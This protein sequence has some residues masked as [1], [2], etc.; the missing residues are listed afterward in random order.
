[1]KP[2]ETKSVE[3]TSAGNP[4]TVPLDDRDIYRARRSKYYP[5]WTT[6]LE[7]SNCKTKE[8]GWKLLSYTHKTMDDMRA[9]KSGKNSAAALRAIKVALIDWTPSG[10]IGSGCVINRRFG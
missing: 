1:M 8:Q 2:W 9:Y 4:T 5:R 3:P 7:L 10:L 6:I